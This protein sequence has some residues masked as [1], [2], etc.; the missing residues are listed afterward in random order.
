MVRRV[1]LH[2]RRL[3]KVAEALVDDED[4]DRVSEHRW[5]L[6]R[7]PLALNSY[8][9]TMIGRRTV[10]LHRFIMDPPPDREV[11][12]IDRNGLNNTRGNLET[13]THQLNIQRGVARRAMDQW[14]LSQGR[15][16]SDSGKLL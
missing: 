16:R 9:R 15:V 4:Y 13:V 14:L 1:D 11:N 2:Y 12:H 10:Y 6:L 3:G 8:A 7:L 5:S